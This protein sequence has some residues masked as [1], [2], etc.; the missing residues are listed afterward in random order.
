MYDMITDLDDNVSSALAHA[1][2]V[3]AANPKAAVESWISM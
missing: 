3:V 2:E 1:Q